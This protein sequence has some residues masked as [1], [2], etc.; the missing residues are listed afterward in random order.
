MEILP[1]PVSKWTNLNG[2]D[3][4]GLVYKNPYRWAMTQESLVQLT[5]LQ[6]HLESNTLI[7]AMERLV[8]MSIFLLLN[9][10]KVI[11]SCA[12]RSIHSARHVFNE[13]FYQSGKMKS[14]EY[15][16]LDSWYQFLNDKYTTGF[17]LS[18]DLICKL[19]Y[20]KYLSRFFSIFILFL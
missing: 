3:V 15:A 9:T 13:Y 10:S 2:T 17:D 8:K 16:L 1:E 11:V 5:M 6:E 19:D 18:G 7:K 14:V 12:F 20:L 4:L